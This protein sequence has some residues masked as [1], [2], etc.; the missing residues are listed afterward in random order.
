MEVWFVETRIKRPNVEGLELIDAVLAPIWGGVLKTP[1]EADPRVA[2]LP[3]G[4]R[5]VYALYW[6]YSEIAN[7][8]LD[9]YLFNPTG[10]LLPEALEGAETIGNTKLHGLLSE[11]VGLFEDGYP[12]D[13]DE[14]CDRLEDE[15]ADEIPT[16]DFDEPIWECLRI[17]F[18]EPAQSRLYAYI[19]AH[20][21]EFF[22]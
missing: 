16:Y 5:A 10:R 13:Q 8:G 9:Q 12:V 14:R 21:D 11:F 1:Y 19:N 6:M 15:D 2:E 18:D 17:E 3:A 22:L 4:L 20:P 7:G